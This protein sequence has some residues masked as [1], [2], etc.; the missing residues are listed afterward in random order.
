MDRLGGHSIYEIG[1]IGVAERAASD[2]IDTL[3]GDLATA[4]GGLLDRLYQ[5]HWRDLTGYIFAKYGSG[6]PEPEDVA[7]TA[8]A[9]FASLDDPASV[10]NPK[11]FL[12][13]T[14]RNIV[15]D[16]QRRAKTRVRYANDFAASQA[17]TQVDDLTAER[18]LLEKERW[19][20]L[21]KTI[22]GL[23]QPKRR[24]LV[25]ARVHRLSYAEIS[26]Q[27]GVPTTTVKR[28]VADA[29]ATC[30]DAIAALSEANASDD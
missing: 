6:P 3:R 11:A 5:L 20:V 19:A 23:P 1:R 17:A 24:L 15:V 30:A 14:A 27:T 29:M 8:F 13:A 18:V 10:E 7:Q 9:R 21:Q 2:V 22:E 25:M 4:R 12:F 16:E 26:R 28:H